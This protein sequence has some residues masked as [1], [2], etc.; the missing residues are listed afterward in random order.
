MLPGR[1]P[2]LKGGLRLPGLA[3]TSILSWDPGAGER[4]FPKG[5]G[6]RIA[7]LAPMVTILLIR[8]GIAE[9]TPGADSERSLTAEG[10]EKSRAAMKGLVNRGYRPSR[11]VCSPYRRAAQ[12]LSC[13]Q[14]AARGGFPVDSWDGL[15]PGAPPAKAEAWLLGEM[16]GMDP[17]GVLALVSH[18]PFLSTFIRHLTGRIVEVK[19]TSCTV[20]R[21][22]GESFRFSG[23][24]TAAELQEG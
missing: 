21:W 11:G 24:L 2:D 22:D 5:P 10:W 13:L 15:K 9:D 17:S 19:K 6:P 1:L 4:F 18:E 23:H 16:A 14:E 3:Q 7:I 8:H 20:L 12:T